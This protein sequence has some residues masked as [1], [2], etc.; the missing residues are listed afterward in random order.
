MYILSLQICERY[1][2]LKDYKENPTHC[3][4]DNTGFS[5]E[6]ISF[7]NNVKLQISQKLLD[8]MYWI[9]GGKLIT[10]SWYDQLLYEIELR[11]NKESY[12]KVGSEDIR[13]GVERLV[14]I[15]MEK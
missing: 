3:S 4:K 8:D 1:Y 12:G 10:P 14:R 15:Y 13:K 11:F 2:F 7:I 9:E 5:S 6:N